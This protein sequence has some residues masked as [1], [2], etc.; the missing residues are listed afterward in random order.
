M[1]GASRYPAGAFALAL[2]WEP[3][4]SLPSV[5]T[6]LSARNFVLKNQTL[7][8]GGRKLM[9]Q[10]TPGE[11]ARSFD[12]DAIAGGFRNNEFALSNALIGAGR[13]VSGHPFV[14]F[15]IAASEAAAS[16]SEATRPAFAF[17]ARA[18]RG[19]RQAL[20]AA[21]NALEEKRE[22]ESWRDFL[23]PAGSSDAWVTAYTLYQLTGAAWPYAP[24][25]LRRAAR[26]SVRWLA[27]HR[28]KKGG[29]A[30]SAAAEDD[31]DSTSLALLAL[32]RFGNAAPAEARAFLRS[33][34]RADGGVSTYPA[35]SGEDSQS[36]YFRSAVEI[37][38]L[39]LA[40][41]EDEI[42][43]EDRKRAIRFLCERQSED[44]IW[45]AYW[46]V[47][48]LYSTWVALSWLRNG[49]EIPKESRLLDS[50]YH[51]SPVGTFE[52]ALQLLCLCQ[53]GPRTRH[54]HH[55]I[56]D[57]LLEE[58]NGDGSWKGDA[59]MRLPHH[60]TLEPQ[61]QIDAGPSFCDP[62]GVFTTATA[63]AALA[64]CVA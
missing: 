31:A 8:D 13:E 54:R 25:N 32:R 33:C 44:G 5:E 6:H 42:E 57:R 29:W 64:C 48:P 46:W 53:L 7:A 55:S 23:L 26:D 63:I 27:A 20:T 18:N 37:T 36:G 39:A 34:F 1:S 4:Q 58:Q 56:I 38:P 12:F 59:M 50:L 28:G 62:N 10:L 43:I 47:S 35:G 16:E 41:L 22:A 30:Y 61:Q 3:G 14:E 11:R 52:A 19:P 2:T 21:M 51:Y 40:A 9:N 24:P 17:I 45:P 15:H 49:Y 60:S